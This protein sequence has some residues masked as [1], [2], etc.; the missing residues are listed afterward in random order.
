MR[1][2]GRSA[3]SYELGGAV[4]ASA[5]LNFFNPADLKLWHDLF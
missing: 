2:E 3:A 1:A 5:S 4:L